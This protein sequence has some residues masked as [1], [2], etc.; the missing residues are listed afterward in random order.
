GVGARGN[1]KMLEPAEAVVTN[2]I[3]IAGPD[4]TSKVLVKSV[5]PGGRVFLRGNVTDLPLADG[6]VVQLSAPPSWATS[7]PKASADDVL[8]PAGARPARR[9]S[10]DARIVESVR[11]RNGRIIDSQEQVGGYPVRPATKRVL[12]VPEDP[13]A[14]QRWLDQ[15][16]AEVSAPSPDWR[17]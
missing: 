15:L 11:R 6:G 12:V 9:D 17:K 3:A 4:T 2:N 7:I 10:V 13:A 1:R 8:R 5:D 14:R 16:D